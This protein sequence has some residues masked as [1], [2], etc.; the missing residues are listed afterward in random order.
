MSAP[1]VMSGISVGAIK[2][3]ELTVLMSTTP[4]SPMVTLSSFAMILQTETYTCFTHRACHKEKRVRS[5]SLWPLGRAPSRLPAPYAAI[6]P[7]LRLALHS[8]RDRGQHANRGRCPVELPATVV[9]Y[10]NRIGTYVDRAARIFGIHDSLQH[11]LSRPQP[12]DPGDIVPV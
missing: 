5:S 11:Q 2:T 12:A 9:G 3:L 7:N 8:L 6:E 4:H 1:W 10:D